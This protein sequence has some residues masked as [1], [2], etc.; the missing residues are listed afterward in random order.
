MTRKMIPFDLSKV[1]ENGKGKD[2][3]EVVYRGGWA[4]KRVIHVP[5]A[6]D[7]HEIL[8]VDGAA[9]RI[10]HFRD[11]KTQSSAEETAFDLML[12]C[13]EPKMLNGFVNVYNPNY[14]EVHE[15]KEKANEKAAISRIACIDLSQFEEGHGL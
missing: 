12:L 13:P 9:G 11:G 3:Y 8:S 15:T 10:W 7:R 5:E 14:V 6:N 4:P 1:D 2:G